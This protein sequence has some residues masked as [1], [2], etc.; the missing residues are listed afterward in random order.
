MAAG[1][2]YDTGAP[3]IE[4]HIYGND[5]LLVRE[6][7]ESEEDAAAVVDQW[8]DVGNVSVIVDDLS[9][10]HGPGDILAPDELAVSDDEDHSIASAPFPA[11]GPSRSFTP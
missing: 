7:C 4:L 8:S 6:L 11:T 3:T 9:A 10:H 2:F 5:Q 1:T